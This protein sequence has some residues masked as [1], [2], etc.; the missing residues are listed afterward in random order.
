MVSA[1]PKIKRARA[2]SGKLTLLITN[3]NQQIFLRVT[4]TDQRILLA[5]FLIVQ[6]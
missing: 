5:I 4:K 2:N 1:V 6:P 3:P